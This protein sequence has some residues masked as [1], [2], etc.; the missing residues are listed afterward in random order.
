MAK[1]KTKKVEEVK[2]E[3]QV[4]EQ[5]EKK[6]GYKRFFLPTVGK[7]VLARNTEEAKKIIN[8]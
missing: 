6:T 4:E 3:E 7:S 1:S 5:K 2:K 8:G